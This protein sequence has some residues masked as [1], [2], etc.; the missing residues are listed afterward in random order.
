MVFIMDFI[1]ICR[2][3]PFVL[4]SRTVMCGILTASLSLIE[5]DILIL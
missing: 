3:Y 1:D 2:K 5:M 4:L